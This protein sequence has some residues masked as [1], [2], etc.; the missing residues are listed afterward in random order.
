MPPGQPPCPSQRYWKVEVGDTLYLIALRLGTT[1][2]ELVRLNPGI[3][4]H[5][6]QV[7]QLIC[8][9]QEACPSGVYWVVAPGDTLYGIARAT[10]A[11]LEKILALNPHVDPLNLQV[12]QLICLP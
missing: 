11:P 6:L 2:E 5:N 7:G 1:V 12:G 9:P 8:L 4:P 3:D 10:G